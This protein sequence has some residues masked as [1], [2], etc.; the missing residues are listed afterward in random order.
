MRGPDDGGRR[1]QGYEN[2]ATQVLDTEEMNPPTSDLDGIEMEMHILYE[3]VQMAR[4]GLEARFTA[5]YG[6]RTKINM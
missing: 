1:E 5:K 2:C 6:T 4:D 3:T